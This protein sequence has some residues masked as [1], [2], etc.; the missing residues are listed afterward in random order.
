MTYYINRYYYK[1]LICSAEC[2]IRQRYLNSL[3]NQYFIFFMRN[4]INKI[5]IMFNIYSIQLGKQFLLSKIIESRNNNS[6]SE[7]I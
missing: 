7:I 4:E 2:W 1:K 6:N 3:F 5:N